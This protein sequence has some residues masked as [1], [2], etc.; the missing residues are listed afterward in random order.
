MHETYIIGKW[1]QI[2]VRLRHKQRGFALE[3]GMIC[4]KPGSDVLIE[5]P[6]G[7]LFQSGVYYM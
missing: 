4:I 2:Y 1:S 6:H 5:C 3:K 7:L